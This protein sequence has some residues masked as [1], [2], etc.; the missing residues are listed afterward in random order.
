[1]LLGSALWVRR[2]FGPISVDQLL[3]N[4]PAP[5]A[6]AVAGPEAEL[7]G[8][9][10]VEAVAIPL[11]A[12]A[13]LALAG[14]LLARKLRAGRGLRRH[15]GATRWRVPLALSLGVFVLGAAVFGET[16]GLPQYLRSVTSPYSMEA[17]YVVPEPSAAAMLTGDAEPTAPQRNLVL[18]F[19][20]SIEESFGD[21]ELFGENLL[22][23]LDAATTGWASIPRFE[24]Y[25]G[26]GWTMA[27]LVGSSCGLPLRGPG[28]GADDLGSNEIGR[29]RDEYLPGARCLGDVLAESGYRNVFLG[30]AD[31]NFASKGTFLRSHG[32][33]EVNDLGVW[34]AGGATERS[35]W[36]LSDRELF[37]GAEAELARLRESG[38]PFNLTILTLD[39][40]EP[41]HLFPYC[42]KTGEEELRDATRC[43]IEQAAAFISGMDERGELADTVVAVVA[44][45]RKMISEGGPFWD[46]LSDSPNRTLVNRFWSPDGVRIAREEADQLSVFATLLDLLD[47]PARDHR[48]GIGV[49]VLVPGTSPGSILDLSPEEYRETVQS[50]SPGLYQ[51]VWGQSEPDAHEALG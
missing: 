46:Q 24:E 5:G 20:E 35:G 31:A 9:A 50:R 3:L 10:L 6:A 38:Q 17:H 13:L 2:T 40:H 14:V 25:E 8:S 19:L 34:E 33:D 42:E 30:G 16:V 11:A 28:R 4:L 36:G 18:I 32:Y 49:S 39:S 29:E 26:G 47:M 15:G 22:A 48:A 7:L 1:M 44:D 43:S 37:A 12:T 23:P 45:H 21:P 51:R 27:G 41:A